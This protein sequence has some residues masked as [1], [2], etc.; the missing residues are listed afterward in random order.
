MQ[1]FQYGETETAH[2]SRRDPNMAAL[3]RRLGMLQRKVTPDI[4]QALVEG[5]VGQQISSKAATTVNQRLR[6]LCGGITP[7]SIGQLDISNIQHCGMT[8]KKAGYIL[9]A[10]DAFLNNAIDPKALEKLDDESVIHQLTK[11]PGI[12]RWTVEMLLLHSLQRPDIFSFDD[13]VIHRNLMAMH[14]LTNL[15]K[16][17]FE[18]YRKLYSPYCSV[19]MIYLWR[20]K[21]EY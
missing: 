11:L 19:A 5:I 14:D 3:I 1:Y 13:L 8:T 10:A 20:Y 17:E 21:Q 9:S 12:G 2:L 18:E 4:F 16:S 7:E 6:D 15:R